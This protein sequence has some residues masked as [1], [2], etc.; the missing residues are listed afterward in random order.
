MPNEFENAIVASVVIIA[1]GQRRIFKP[2]EIA[3]ERDHAGPRSRRGAHQGAVRQSH[4]VPRRIAV[5]L[6]GVVDPP[7]FPILLGESGYVDS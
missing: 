4:R 6:S 7:R 5:G 2:G 3:Q 1:P